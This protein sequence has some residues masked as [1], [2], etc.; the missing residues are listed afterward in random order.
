MWWSLVLLLAGCAIAAF[1]IRALR[2]HLAADAPARPTAQRHPAARQASPARA[3]DKAVL[4]PLA[5][6]EAVRTPSPLAG[7]ALRAHARSLHRGALSRP[8]GE[9]RRPGAHRRR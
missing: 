2:Q 1:T 7:D 5:W 8:R 9:R 3:A 6:V 4:A